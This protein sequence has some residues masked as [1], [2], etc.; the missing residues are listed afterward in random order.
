[1]EDG[2]VALEEDVEV[3][4]LVEA[5]VELE[6]FDEVIEDGKVVKMRRTE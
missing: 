6:G 2:Q 3:G 5:D 1:M 4:E